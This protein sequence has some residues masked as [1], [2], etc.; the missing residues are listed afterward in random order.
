[1]AE[2][3]SRPVQRQAGFNVPGGSSGSGSGGGASTT[4][5]ITNNTNGSS[6]STTTLQSDASSSATT[7]S[8][9]TAT[10]YAP[11]MR[12][13]TND[14]LGKSSD[15]DVEMGDDKV[16]VCSLDTDTGVRA[17]VRPLSCATRI[18]ADRRCLLCSYSL[19]QRG[20]LPL[21][22]PGSVVNGTSTST[23]R[24]ESINDLSTPPDGALIGG[25]APAHGK[26]GGSSGVRLPSLHAHA[27]SP[28][29][30][31][32][33]SSHVSSGPASLSSAQ[34]S[35]GRSSD[36]HLYS[37]SGQPY[38]NASVKP[39]LSTSFQLS[40]ER[41]SSRNVTR[42]P[43]GANN[44]DDDEEEEEEEDDDDV[45]GNTPE[46][47]GLQHAGEPSPPTDRQRPTD[48]MEHED[49]D[50]AGVF[51]FSSPCFG[52]RPLG[53]SDVPPLSPQPASEAAAAAQ[54]AQRVMS[55]SWTAATLGKLSLGGPS[56]PQHAQGSAASQRRPPFGTSPR[57]AN[58]YGGSTGSGGMSSSSQALHSR[59]LPSSGYSLPTAGQYR[60]GSFQRRPQYSPATLHP[61]TGYS[62][63]SDHRARSSSR[64]RHEQR[65]PPV[66]KMLHAEEGDD[67]TDED[68]AMGQ[69][70]EDDDATED[71]AEARARPAYAQRY[72]RQDEAPYAMPHRHPSGQQTTMSASYERAQTG[73]SRQYSSDRFTHLAVGRHHPYAASPSGAS[74]GNGGMLAYS[75]N[76]ARAAFNRR[77]SSFGSNTGLSASPSGAVMLSHSPRYL[78]SVTARNTDALPGSV[79]K[80]VTMTQ[81]YG[82]GSSPDGPARMMY[83]SHHL[84]PTVDNEA[85]GEDEDSGYTQGYDEEDDPEPQDASNLSLK[86]ATS[87]QPRSSSGMRASA[88]GTGASGEVESAE[89]TEVNAIR[90]RLGGAANCSAF[91][92]KL[93]YL[94][95]RPELYTK[96]IH[97]SESGDS[98]ILINDPEINNEFAA[99]VLPKLFKHGNNASFVRQLNLYGFQRVPSSRLLDAAEVDAARRLPH[100]QNIST[101]LQLYGSHSSFAHPRFKKD[102]EGLLPSMK[103]R[104]S[105]KTKKSGNG[106]ATG[107][108]G[109]GDEDE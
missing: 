68:D 33:S 14:T 37:I 66:R 42:L 55:P 21:P 75:P 87:K 63:S 7:A 40:A 45:F 84:S 50:A 9:D 95:C 32:I 34:W 35:P 58:A 79:P 27:L 91:I 48:D 18:G 85:D 86:N 89:M 52:P 13:A 102:Q 88:G 30:A 100:G 5:T 69:D 1:M 94:M 49:G 43:R 29:L 109:D 53:T 61:I 82:F 73:L 54:R 97:W 70:G 60:R 24:T 2:A 41:G 74:A 62:R 26:Q 51:D 107:G 10:S 36:P 16:S 80:Y 25:T 15:G 44:M 57:R 71:E 4:T 103:P 31:A 72:A 12:T 28:R 93:W 101:A 90:E 92:S 56:E 104:S 96:Y 99:A 108:G 39:Y 38:S 59:S 64:H 20:L 83:E 6:A 65:P 11:R 78:Q 17:R 81:T 22:I 23:V 105:K 3:R 47:L 67:E 106:A 46:G 77:R 8:S 76:N 19:C 98:V